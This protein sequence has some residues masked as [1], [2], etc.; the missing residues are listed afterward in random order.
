MPPRVSRA[1]PGLAFSRCGAR[2]RLRNGHCWCRDRALVGLTYS[3]HGWTLASVDEEPEDN[4]DAY[5]SR[6]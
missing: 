6:R 4:E 1:G 2:I 5:S 3:G